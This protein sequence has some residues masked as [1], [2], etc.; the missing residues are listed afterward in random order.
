[1]AYDADLCRK[2]GNDGSDPGGTSVFLQYGEGRLPSRLSRPLLR[3][4][5]R[6]HDF[7]LPDGPSAPRGE[8][9]VVIKMCS[10]QA[11]CRSNVATSQRGSSTVRSTLSV[12]KAAARRA[13]L[14]CWEHGCRLLL[15]LRVLRPAKRLSGLLY[16]RTPSRRLYLRMKHEL[17]RAV[18]NCFAFRAF[19]AIG[20]AGHPPVVVREAARWRSLR[21]L[22]PGTG[23]NGTSSSP[24]EPQHARHPTRTREHLRPDRFPGADMY[25]KFPEESLATAAPT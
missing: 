22:A 25:R 10:E 5:Q 23:R 17:K 2:P 16:I 11:L 18:R 4:P 15:D 8:D 12:F 14:T 13:G 7:A 9:E 6:P 20:K 3:L 21:C 1:M 24:T 19:A